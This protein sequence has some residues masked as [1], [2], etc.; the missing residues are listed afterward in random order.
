MVLAYEFSTVTVNGSGITRKGSSL[1]LE[2]A[3][4]INHKFK[5]DTGKK[6]SD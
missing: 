2:A 1:A 3:T 4:E 6:V 5:L